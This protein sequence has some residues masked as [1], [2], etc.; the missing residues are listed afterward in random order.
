MVAHTSHHI[1][2]HHSY[3]TL[4]VGREV[5]ALSI[6][7]LHP[8]EEVLGANQTLFLCTE[9]GEDETSFRAYLFK[10]LGQFKHHGIATG[11]VVGARVYCYRVRTA[12][13][14]I[15]AAQAQ[16]VVMR[17]YDD[18]FVS[19]LFVF[20]R[21]H[22]NNVMRLSLH[23]C[24]VCP[25]SVGEIM[26]VSD[27]LLPRNHRFKLQTAKLADNIFRGE[28]IAGSGRVSASELLRSQVFHRLLHVI[29]P[30]SLCLQDKGKSQ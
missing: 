20:S 14:R 12:R 13:T 23:A 3:D 9:E 25:I 10:I 29:L 24:A 18:V 19:Q 6:G 16:M 11:I 30:L 17:T 8:L 22:S 28:G 26:I 4:L 27:G 2:I 1:Q 21:K 15:L 7:L 5:D